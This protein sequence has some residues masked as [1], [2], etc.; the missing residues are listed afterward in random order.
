MLRKSSKSFE[1]VQKL[2]KCAKSWES[3]PKAEKVYQSVF[4][5]AL[6]NIIPEKQ[7]LDEPNDASVKRKYNEYSYTNY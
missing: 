5:V 7:S 2:R 1:Y 3:V 6:K 4:P